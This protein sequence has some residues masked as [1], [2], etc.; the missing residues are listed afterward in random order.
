MLNSNIV[1]RIATYALIYEVSLSPKPG[2]V[3]LI[4]RGAHKDM[5]YIDF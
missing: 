4:D 2:L 5:D 1:A 3:S